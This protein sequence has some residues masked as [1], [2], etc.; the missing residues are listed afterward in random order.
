MTRKRTKVNDLS[1]GHYAANKK[2][3]FKTPVLRPDSY[4]CS[5]EYIVAKWRITVAGTNND[6]NKNNK[7]VL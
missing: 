7:A 6:K 4:D 3:R 2:I 1:N 5:G